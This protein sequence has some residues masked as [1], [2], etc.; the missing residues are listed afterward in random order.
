MPYESNALFLLA[1][2]LVAGA[3]SGALARKAHLPAVTGQILAGI[4]LGPS[5]FH[6]FGDGIAESLQPVID[7]ATGLMAVAAGSHLLLRRLRNAKRRLL[8]LFAF[9]VTLTPLTVLIAI[10]IAGGAAWQSAVLLAAVAVSTAPATVLA[11]VKET[12]SRGVFVKTLVAGVALNNL[13]CIA[14]FE[15][16]YAAASASYESGG[17][18][19]LN[20]VIL[21]PLRQILL[22]IALGSGIGLVL[23]AITRKIV[24]SDRLAAASLIAILLTVGIGEV[25]AISPLLSCLFLGITLANLTPDKDEIGHVV[26]AN[27]E[28]AIFAVFFTVAGTELVFSTLVSGGAVAVAVFLARAVGKIGSAAAAMK[29]AGAT[30]NLRRFLGPALLPQAGLAVGLSL[31][32]AEN[33]SLTPIRDLFLAVVLTVVTANELIGPLCTRMALVWSGDAGKDR[34][35]LIDFLG[36]ENIA[37]GFRAKTKEEAIEQLTSILISTNRLDLSKEALVA[38]ALERERAASTCLGEGLAVPHGVLE[39][40]DGIYGAMGISREGLP[41]ETPD[42]EPVHCMVLLATPGGARDR[43]LEVLAALARAVG[44]DPAIRQ[45]L[46]HARTPAHAYEILHAEEHAESFNYFLD[47]EE[48]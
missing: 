37:T 1:L 16:A 48:S 28:Y 29:L 40:G 18:G 12:R 4:L 23:I 32:V 17:G 47:D 27:F 45:Q 8:L 7:F 15:L 11:I 3:L 36:E 30:R 26:F 34:A 46:F 42:G 38:S 31:L 43:H 2:L 25:L 10:A 44:S 13:A 20:E 9:E 21:A 5:V 41:F 35:R 33:P 19:N 24:R 39:D 6:V 22:S 14:L